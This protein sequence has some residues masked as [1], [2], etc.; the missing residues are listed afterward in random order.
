MTWFYYKYF[1]L[2]NHQFG[3]IK[4]GIHYFWI[5]K[6]TYE[7]PL[8]LKKGYLGKKARFVINLAE[9]TPRNITMYT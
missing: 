5:V 1:V 3:N 7:L 8:A 6:H 9:E 4:G 2:P